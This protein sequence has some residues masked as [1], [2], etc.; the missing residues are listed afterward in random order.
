MRMEITKSNRKS[1]STLIGYQIKIGLCVKFIES[2]VH[3][4]CFVGGKDDSSINLRRCPKI[5]RYIQLGTSKN[6]FFNHNVL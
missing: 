4:P 3:I 2:V 1:S 5:D 6:S